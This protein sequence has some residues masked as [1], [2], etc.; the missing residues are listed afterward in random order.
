MSCDAILSALADPN[1]RAI[2]DQL[3]QGPAPVVALAKTMPISRPAVSQHLK[4]LTDAGLLDCEQQGKRRVYRLSQTGAAA[5]RDY[6]NT[7]WDDALRAFSDHAHLKAREAAMSLDPIV[8]TLTVPLDPQHAFELFASDLPSW[9]PV[10]THSISAETQDTPKEVVVEPRV[11]GKIR[12][13]KRDGSIHDWATI[14]AWEPG[15]R[16]ALNWYV[17]RSESE[18][19]F[20]DV[21]FEAQDNGTR[22]TLIHDGWAALGAPAPQIRGGYYTG[23]DMV[24]GECFQRHCLAHLAGVS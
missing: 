23:W 2:V 16:L 12:E 21:R 22:V 15:A 10:A 5:L 1:R 9:W 8:K 3:R 7:L 11:G 4:V 24:L 20:I 17:G 6:V 19:T 18:A 14:T 13:T